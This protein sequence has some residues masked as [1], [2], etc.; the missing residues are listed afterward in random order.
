[1]R[2]LIVRRA[3]PED[4]AALGVLI[5]GFAKGHPAEH[6]AR[7][8][9]RMRDAFF[10]NKPVGHVLLAEKSGTAIGFGA[11]RETNDVFWSVYGGAGLGLYVAPPHRGLGVALCIIAAI[12][13]E[14]RNQG[15][16][17]LEASYDPIMASLYERVGVGRIERACHVSAIAFETLAAATGMPARE[18]VGALPDKAMNHV[19]VNPGI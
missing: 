17:F 5:D 2:D 18:I 16:H 6:H 15:G 3:T 7:S 13:A 14:I 9:N 12:C 1:M 11:W 4:A 8:M 19:P 10:A